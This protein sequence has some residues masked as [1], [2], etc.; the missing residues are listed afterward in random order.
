MY[1]LEAR[2][3]QC[4]FAFKV[5]LSRWVKEKMLIKAK[6]WVHASLG[7]VQKMQS[8]SNISRLSQKN[9]VYHPL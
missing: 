1:V 6:A 3:I 2:Y 4:N 9:C 7:S 8:L 5:N